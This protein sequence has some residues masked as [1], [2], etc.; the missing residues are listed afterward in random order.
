M[1]LFLQVSDHRFQLRYVRPD[2]VGVPGGRFSFAPGDERFPGVMAC[3]AHAGMVSAWA[4]A[5][6]ALAHLRYSG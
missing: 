4:A 1:G 6:N 5:R 2:E 3:S